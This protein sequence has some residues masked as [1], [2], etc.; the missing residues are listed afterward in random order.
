MFGMLPFERHDDNFFDLFDNFERKFFGNTTAALPDFRTDI[1]DTDD[2]YVLEAELPGF[3]KEDITLNIKEGVLTIHAEHSE[4]KDEKDDKGNYL[5]RE[6][7]YGS[8]SRS[9]DITGIDEAGITAGYNNGV[10]ELTLPK[11]QPVIPEAR[12][13]AI[14]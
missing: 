6:R 14:E 9:F 12:H 13:I 2:K 11:T 4:N 5:R 8:F 1:R 3:Q 10:L 7:R